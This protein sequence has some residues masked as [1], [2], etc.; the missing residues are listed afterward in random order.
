VKKSKTWP[1]GEYREGGKASMLVP[2][3][4]RQWK[5]APPGEPG[6]PRFIR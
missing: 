4:E 1:D 3:R 5:T 6:I 2:W